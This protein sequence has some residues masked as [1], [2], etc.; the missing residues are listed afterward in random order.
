[1]NFMSR[2][3][4]GV[5]LCTALLLT[6]A[7]LSA[8]WLI[9]LCAP[10]DPY[11]NRMDLFELQRKGEQ[12]SHEVQVTIERVQTK[13]TIIEQLVSGEMTLIEAAA[14]F[15]SLHEDPRTWHN[16]RNPRPEHDEGERWCYVVMDYAGT[17]VQCERSESQ[18][19]ALRQRL[20][21]ELQELVECHGAVKLPD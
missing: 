11:G 14:W 6:V 3:L 4:S 12:L 9:D 20:E 18:A 16:P 5:L 7:S 15:R 19:D 21:A 13:D 8:E 1:M 10:L 2:L 17:K